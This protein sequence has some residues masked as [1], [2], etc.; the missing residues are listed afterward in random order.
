MVF[1]EVNKLLNYKVSLIIPVY[2]VEKYLKKCLDSATEQTLGEI[3]IIIVNDGSTDNS[4]SIICEYEVRDNRIKV[5]NQ[6]NSGVSAARNA[7]LS[8]AS[9]E[10][11][12]F[13]DSDDW[14]DVSFLE[15][16]YLAAKEQNAD[17]AICNYA[18]VVE[19]IDK[20]PSVKRN[21]ADLLTSSEALKKIISESGIRSYTWDKLYKRS[22]F[23]KNNISYPSVKCYEDM[24]TTFKLFYYANR[25]AMLKDCLYF[26]LQRKTSITKRINNGLIHD[27]IKALTM[28]REFLKSKG[29][30]KKYFREYKYLCFKMMLYSVYSLL[31]LYEDKNMEAKYK[32][33]RHA[34]KEINLL[35]TIKSAK[36]DQEEIEVA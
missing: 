21:K 33:I 13:L 25:I 15:K 11:I 34:F 4:L 22:L 14:I 2:N 3:E 6:K 1:C 17:I 30:F 24:A 32:T 35:M 7:G 16:M 26:Y 9:G 18:S 20:M 23:T 10:F 5:I 29:C 28:M 12:A 31:V 19:G 36:K 27:N 8:V